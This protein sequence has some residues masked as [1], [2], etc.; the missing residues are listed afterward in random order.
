MEL[1]LTKCMFFVKE[2][3]FLGYVVS[4]EGLVPSEDNL[5]AISNFPVPKNFKNIQ[6]FLGLTAYFRRFIE[7]YSII[8]KPLTDFLRKN[9][10]FT[11]G[12]L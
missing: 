7:G 3:K 2:I 1:N 4:A 11:F 8:A 5:K 10:E 12:D 9:V 6:S